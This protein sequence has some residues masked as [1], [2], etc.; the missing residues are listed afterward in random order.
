MVELPLRKNK[1][2]KERGQ[3]AGL[4]EARSRE[5]GQILQQLG[6]AEPHCI[7]GRGKGKP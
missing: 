5:R 7:S 4:D 3:Q 1:S 2:E 6:P